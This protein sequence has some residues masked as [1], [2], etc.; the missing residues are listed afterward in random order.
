VLAFSF[1]QGSGTTVPDSSGKANN[2][3][4]TNTTWSASGKFGSALS[5]NGTSSS[6]TVPDNA[7]LDLTTGMTLE[8]WVNPTTTGTVW[9][10][11]IMKQNTASLVYA[12][13]GNVN[14]NRPSAR[15][16]T[17]SELNT[18]G[19]AAVPT[20][21]WTFLTE[22]YDGT[23]LRLYV[24]GTQASSKAVT[25][26]MP[27]STG[28]LRI[29]GNSIWAEWFSGLIDNVRVYNRALAAT[30]IQADMTTR[31]TP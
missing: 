19:T 14:T 8:G 31:V 1:D 24:N 13:Y 3:T 18:D 12:L 10:T 16:F 27:N 6:V 21:A 17:S 25:G 15:A 4:L 20:S 23:T 9:R 11:L 22:T 26:S 5:F 30:E 7:T 29:G 28:P 2:G